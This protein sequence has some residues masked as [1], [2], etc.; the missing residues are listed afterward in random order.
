MPTSFLTGLST[1]VKPY[2]A[3]EINGKNTRYG[4]VNSRNYNRKIIKLGNTITT[5]KLGIA[6]PTTAPTGSGGSG[7]NLY[8]CY[9]YVNKKFFDPLA[10]EGLDP[11]IRSNASDVLTTASQ[12]SAPTISMT[13]STDPQVTDIWLYVSDNVAGPFYRLP[14]NYSVA[15]TGSPSL[16]GVTSVDTAQPILETDNYPLDT[17]RIFEQV[18][19]FGM[20]AGFVPITGTADATIGSPTITISTG[21]F[22]DGVLALYFQFLDDTS[23]GPDGDGI[24][25]ANWASSTTLTLVSG[26][27][28]PRNYDGPANKVGASFRIYRPSNQLQFTKRY[29]IDSTPGVVDPDFLVQGSG[30]ITGICVPSTGFSVRMHCNSN[31]RKSVE[32]LDLTQGL[33]VKRFQTAS[34]Y[35]MSCPRAYCNAGGRMFYY[36]KD[37]GVIEDRGMNHVPVT[38]NVI[39]NLIRSLSNSSADIA[40]MVYDE[41]RNLMFLSVAPS[42][43]TKGYYMIVYNLTSDVWNLWFMLPNVLSMRRIKQTDGTVVVKM[44]SSDG[45]ITVWPS[46]GFNEAVGTSILAQVSTTDDTTHLTATGTPFPTTGDKLVDRWIMTWNPADSIPTYQFARISDNTD[47][48]LTLDT[49]IGPNSSTALSPVPSAGDAIWCGPIQSILGPNWDYNSVPDDDGHLMDFSIITSGLDASSNTNLELF[50]NFETVSSVGG[51][52]VHSL[53]QD[54][55]YDPDHQSMKMGLVKSI[56]TTGVT[57]WRIVDNNEYPLSIKSIVRRIKAVNENLNRNAR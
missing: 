28:A 49:F 23:G 26:T 11:Y 6:Y 44:G 42:G 5:Q 25:I 4:L 10:L 50:R 1:E 38:L 16:T 36:D 18:N 39:P 12:S 40:E 24:H 2:V 31:N 52:M 30:P 56:E 3:G 13:A 48:R 9:I 37:A 51:P 29:N 20:G 45:S 43:Y 22:P 55:N 53:Y 7:T 47:S 34:A 8:Y 14:T 27:G 21:T 57:G 54:G 41:S 19:G 35:A 33:P 46:A 15:N 17:C 32:I